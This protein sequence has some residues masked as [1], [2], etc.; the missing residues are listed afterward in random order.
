L[1]RPRAW[2]ASDFQKVTKRLWG[3]GIGKIPGVYAIHGFLFQL[4]KPGQ[5]IIEV[6]GSKMYVDP[7]GLPKSYIKTFQALMLSSAWEELTTR[8]FEEA[9]K[10]GNV[11]LDLGANIGYFTLLAARLTGEKGRVY[12]FEPEP[13]NYSLLLKNIELNGYDNVVAMQ[14]VVTDIA[15]KVKLFIDSKDTGAHSIFRPGTSREY[16]EVESVVP[17]EFFKDKEH[18][19]D[20]VKMDVEG[21]EASVL[22]GME[23][24]IKENEKLVIFM[25]FYP[26]A[27][28]RAGSSPEEFARKLIEDYRFSVLAIGEYTTDKKYLKINSVDEL[29][30]LCKGGKTANLLLKRS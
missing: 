18:S 9:I 11:I 3:T 25:E 7:K 8:L 14:K 4:L 30:K 17:D 24:I 6:R 20:V 27:I 29:M 26:G 21:A 28:K 2:L 12:S 19:I 10:E 5:S 16:I 22:K 15:G 23:R 1:S 13:T